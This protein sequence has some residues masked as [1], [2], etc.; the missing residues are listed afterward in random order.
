[1]QGIGTD[2]GAGR[3]GQGSRWYRTAALIW[4][5]ACLLFV[6]LNVIALG[7]ESASEAWYRVV[8]ASRPDPV[9]EKY[10]FSQVVQNYPGMNRTA[11]RELLRETWSRPMAFEPFTQFKERTATGRYVNVSPH[12][13]R[14]TKDQGP[15]PPSSDAVN[16]FLFGGSTV[17]NYG[18]PDEQTMA[19]FLQGVLNEAGSARPVRVY[20]FGR[21]QYYSSQERVLFEKLLSEGFVP[22]VAVFLD[23]LNEFHATTDEPYLT[24]RLSLAFEEMVQGKPQNLGRLALDGFERLP[25]SRALGAGRAAVDQVGMDPKERPREEDYDDDRVLSRV[26]TRYRVNKRMIESVARAFGV[27]PVFVWQAVP[28][29]AYDADWARNGKFGSHT[30]SKF[31]YPRMAELARQRVLGNSFVWCAEVHREVPEPAYVDAVHYSAE[32][33]KAMARCMA[34]AITTGGELKRAGTRPKR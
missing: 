16:V 31:G 21:G 6:L 2:N 1:M 34:D 14:L 29:F 3:A 26:I 23:G 5:D 13:F 11:L 25:V 8:P 15:W 19:S 24:E 20:N 17:F 18:L 28:M 9:T 10:G 32:M 7:V 33:S 12:G 22:A 30:Y 27:R 4:L